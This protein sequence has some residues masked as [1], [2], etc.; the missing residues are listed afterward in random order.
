MLPTT[1]KNNVASI[2]Q[3]PPEGESSQTNV[4]A[5][6]S[7][8]QI[9]QLPEGMLSQIFNWLECDHIVQVHDTCKTF[10][11]VVRAQNPD[12]LFYARLPPRFRAL[13]QQSRPWQKRMV[14]NGQHPFATE[15]PPKEKKFLNADRHAAFLCFHTLKKMTTSSRYLPVEVFTNA[16]RTNELQMGCTLNSNHLLL[17]NRLDN[18]ARLL[19]SDETGSWSEQ[20]VTH[21]YSGNWL[22]NIMSFGNCRGLYT[23]LFSQN[24]IEYL[25]SDFG[26]GTCQL[27]N[28]QSFEDFYGDAVSLSGKYLAIYT[29]GVAIRAILCLN[30]QGEWVPMRMTE[31]CRYAS[32]THTF[33]G[34]DFSPSGHLL[35]I[36][37]RKSLSIMSQDSR[38]CWKLLSM[39]SKWMSCSRLNEARLS[40]S[41]TE[42][43]PSERWLLVGLT[44]KFVPFLVELIRLDPAG[45]CIP[46]QKFICRH[47]LTF[48]PAG[49][50][51]VCR[52]G[53]CGYPLL[54]LSPKTGKWTRFGNLPNPAVG[55]P[56][57]GRSILLTNVVTLSQCDNYML[58]SSKDGL[59][60]IWGRQERW[61]VRGWEQHDGK[62]IYAEFSQSGI[63][64][65][66]VDRSSIRIWGRDEG[67]LW[68]VK[69]LIPAPGVLSAHFHPVAEHLILFRNRDG[70]RVWEVRKD[71]SG[72][73]ADRIRCETSC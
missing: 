61:K 27:I 8:M 55:P 18:R 54:R 17:Y 15:L 47:D 71:Y 30:D 24:I 45:N 3:R 29:P 9:T 36:R 31:G 70:V 69:G 19:G 33:E 44:R 49:N 13:Y 48:S 28:Q 68:R 38:G 20:V 7:Q 64:A 32:H 56:P 22:L 43:S 40:Y 5:I 25:K 4:P 1:Q 26:L 23:N 67:G 11:N 58:I 42:F 35:A 21:D 14:R 46:M 10:R 41:Y 51:L 73:K 63:H 50:Y 37:C 12:A 39:S 60:E 34:L 53:S 16:C 52:L 59:V 57:V 65:L 6:W 2:S 72:E 62:V 66:T